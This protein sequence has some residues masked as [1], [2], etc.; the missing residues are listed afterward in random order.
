[1]NILILTMNFAPPVVNGVAQ[2]TYDLYLNLKEQEWV[3]EIFVICSRYNSLDFNSQKENTHIIRI[4]EN[5]SSFNAENI[6]K[7]VAEIYKNTQIDIVHYHEGLSEVFLEVLEYIRFNFQ[8]RI[9]TTFHISTLI[10]NKIQ[11]VEELQIL[12]AKSELFKDQVDREKKIIKVS[13]QVICVSNY[14]KHLLQFMVPEME[15]Q[16]TVLHNALY[17]KK[18]T[19][20]EMR[21]YSEYL[22]PDTLTLIYS[23]RVTVDKGVNYLIKAIE[24]FYEAYPHIAIRL[25]LAG[26]LDQ[27]FPYFSFIRYPKLFTFTGLLDHDELIGLYKKCAIGIFCS[28]AESF[29]YSIIEMMACNLPV[30]VSGMDGIEE[31][32]SNEIDSLYVPVQ[33]HNQIRFI[34]PGNIKDAIFRLYS[35][36]EL[37]KTLTKN[38]LKKVEKEFSYKFYMKEL[39]KVYTG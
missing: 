38:A 19:Y 3:K 39:Q 1:M 18:S 16:L 7:Y 13:D 4:P 23:G 9:I 6:L 25:I 24:E 37:T 12:L 26:R 33:I 27:Y 30:I 36:K 35:E 14:M 8:T 11:N 28:L 32:C 29:G 5:Q 10:M 20:H 15:S 2:H 22:D 31:I 17:M 34:S 21:A